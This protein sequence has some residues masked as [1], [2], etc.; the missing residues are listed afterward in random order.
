MTCGRKLNGEVFKFNKLHS[1]TEI[2][3]N[4]RLIIKENLFL[5]PNTINLNAI[6][7]LENYSHQASLIYLNEFANINELNETINMYL[8]QQPDI[9]FG[10]S[11][12]QINGL[13]IRILGQKAEQLY[14]CLKTIAL[15]LC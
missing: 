10:I 7:Q 12:P 6:G 9:S 5:E 1:L 3:K 14:D 4:N 11:E 13:I 2:Y 15:I 8:S